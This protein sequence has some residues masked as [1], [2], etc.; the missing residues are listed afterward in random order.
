MKMTYKQ[1]RYAARMT[2]KQVAEYLEL[3]PQTIARYERTNHAPKVIL[4][5]CYCL[6]VRC[7]ELADVIVLKIGLLVTVISGHHLERNL[8]V[9]KFWPCT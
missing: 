7:H 5:V 6:L 9:E 8:P 1:A 3:S 2:K 4:S